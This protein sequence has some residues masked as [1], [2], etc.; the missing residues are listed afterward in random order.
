MVVQLKFITWSYQ[1]AGIEKVERMKQLAKFA[2]RLNAY[3]ELNTSGFY[4]NKNTKFK[5]RNLRA[6]AEI[7]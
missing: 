4:K 5:S 1:S 2:N 6:I 3:I 7:A